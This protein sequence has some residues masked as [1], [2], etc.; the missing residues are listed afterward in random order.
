M[1]RW[2]LWLKLF[3]HL[4]LCNFFVS[5]NCCL[6]SNMRDEEMG[7]LVEV[8]RTSLTVQFLC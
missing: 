2:E 7:T 3:G 8:I 5:E 1:K 4:L 6:E